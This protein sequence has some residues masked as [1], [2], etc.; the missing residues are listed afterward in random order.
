M[1]WFSQWKS[2]RSLLRLAKN[3][4]AQA[5]KALMNLLLKPAHSLAWQILRNQADA[6]DVVQ[7]AFL[8]LW[9]SSENFEGNSSL[10][11]Y[12]TKIVMNECY[13]FIRKNPKYAE[14]EVTNDHQEESSN[15]EFDLRL[16]QQIVQQALDTLTAKQRMVLVL[17]AFHDMTASEIGQVMNLNKNSVDQLIWRA[18]TA[19]REKLAER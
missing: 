15:F 1:T 2:D 14:T 11:T 3:G 17:W 9:R 5:V 7:E 4:D 18:K 10:K 13:S 16:N 8:L 12:F 19:L 6:E